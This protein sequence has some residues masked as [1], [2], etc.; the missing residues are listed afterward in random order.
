MKIIA[1]GGGKISRSPITYADICADYGVTKLYSA[2]RERAY[3]EKYNHPLPLFVDSGGHSYVKFNINKVGLHAGKRPPP[4]KTHANAYMRMIEKYK[5]KKWVFAELDAYHT[6]D[7]GIDFVNQ[8]AKNARSIGGN[9]T[10][11]RVYHPY[12]DEV[13]GKEYLT[14]LREWIDDGITYIGISQ[15]SFDRNLYGKIFN[16]TRDKIRLHGF[17]MTRSSILEKY[18]FYSTDS[19]SALVIPYMNKVVPTA[20]GKVLTMKAAVKK[21]DIRYLFPM[22][23]EKMELDQE[24]LTRV[25]IKIQKDAEDFYTKLWAARGVVWENLYK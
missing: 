16:I 22:N 19:T 11:L 3:I 25:S 1:A 9:F 6:D 17:A 23:F 7:L 8:M 24:R 13:Q 12:L 10:Y 14:T 15:D 18:P 20:Y 4:A 21:K 5:D 2:L